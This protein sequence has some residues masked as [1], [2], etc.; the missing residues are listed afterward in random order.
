MHRNYS[1]WLLMAA[2][3]YLKMLC[4]AQLDQSSTLSTLPDHVLPILK[5]CID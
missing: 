3:I 2:V 5:D 1:L 4:R